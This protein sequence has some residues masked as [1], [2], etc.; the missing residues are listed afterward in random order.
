MFAL[1]SGVHLGTC[2]WG[3]VSKNACLR[4]NFYLPSVWFVVYMDV[5]VIDEN[6]YLYLSNYLS[7]YMY[8]YL[9]T[10]ISLNVC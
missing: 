5:Y 4:G 7:V 1:P 8:I 9:S 10:Y 6:I 2:V 3:S